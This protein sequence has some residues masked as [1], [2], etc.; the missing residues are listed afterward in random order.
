[1][2]RVSTGAFKTLASLGFPY[3][4][5]PSGVIQASDGTLYGTTGSGPGGGIVFRFDLSSSTFTTLHRFPNDDYYEEYPTPLLRGADGALYGMTTY[6]G[7]VQNGLIFRMGPPPDGDGD[8]VEDDADNCPTIENPDQED[9][10]GDGLGDV[11][12]NCPSESN[13][14]QV[15]SDGDGAGDACDVPSISVADVSVGEAAGSAVVTLT[16]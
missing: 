8:G 6:G 14:S 5:G 10:D 2:I 1:R 11:C 9:G 4:Y 3:G 13:A 16:L 12:D 15:D 7:R